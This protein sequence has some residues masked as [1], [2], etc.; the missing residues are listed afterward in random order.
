MQAYIRHGW[1]TK[2]IDP[3]D[4]TK[5]LEAVAAKT[6]SQLIPANEN[7]NWQPLGGFSWKCDQSAILV[8]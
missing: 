1:S 6:S 4:R 2:V 3:D 8:H 5:D 7:C